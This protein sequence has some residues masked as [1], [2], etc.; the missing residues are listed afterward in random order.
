M[1]DCIVL[2]CKL[3]ELMNHSIFVL[4]TVSPHSLSIECCCLA[5]RD[6]SNWT[7][8]TMLIIIILL[9]VDKEYQYFYNEII[10]N[11]I[12]ISFT[13]FISILISVFH[14]YDIF[15]TSFLS[16]SSVL[17][18]WVILLISPANVCVLKIYYKCPELR[19]NTLVHIHVEH[20]TWPYIYYIA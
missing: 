6:Y 3:S 17:G 10:I 15:W 1:Y 19:T 12:I 14:L 11:S 4:V 20:K 8:Q 5:T 18:S 16:T 13:N 2:P 7:C 9:G